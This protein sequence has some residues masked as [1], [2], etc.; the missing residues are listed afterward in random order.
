MISIT[1]VRDPNHS[2]L[3]GSF[4]ALGFRSIFLHND[5][6]IDSGSLDNVVNVYDAVGD[7][8]DLVASLF[9]LFC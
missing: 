8:E 9:R 5:L 7:V 6:S 2:A 4:A 1:F 3:L